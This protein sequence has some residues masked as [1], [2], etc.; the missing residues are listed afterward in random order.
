MDSQEM[1]SGLSSALIPSGQEFFGLKCKDKRLESNDY[2]RR[3]LSMATEV[4]HQEMFESNF[5]LQWNE[6]LRGLAVFGTCNLYTEWD[7]T[8]GQLNY[9][10]YPIS[11]YQILEDKHL[12]VD[13]VILTF[14][15]TARQAVQEFGEDKVSE[16]VKE[17]AKDA[18]T[19]SKPFEFIQ[20]V[21]PRKERNPRLTDSKNWPW[22]SI[23]V[24]VAGKTIVDEGGFERFP[25][26]VARWMKGSS[27][28]YG[29]GQGTE[30][31]SAVKVL[32]AIM[33][34][35]VDCG[36]RW[37]NPPREVALNHEGRVNVTPG[38]VNY[39]AE[40]GNTIKALDAGVM[41]NFPITKE[42]LELQRDLIHK[43]FYRDIFGQLSTLTGDRR[44]TTEIIER[45]R[46]GLRRLAMPVS[47]I[48]S[49]LLTP[50]IER[51]VWLLIRN[52]R[53]PYPPDEL[54]G[55][56]GIEYLGELGLALRNQQAKGFIQWV[57]V[58]A[59]MGAVFPDALDLVGVDRGVRR[60]A[61]TSGV[62]IE[63]VSTEEEVATKREARQKATAAQAALQA[64]EVAGKAYPGATK[65]P[66]EGSPAAELVGAGKE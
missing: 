9:K 44:T 25:F 12:N 1:A 36:N 32:Q 7:A 49:E 37:V 15:F 22:E 45:I 13:T 64:V 63:D 5:M 62:N 14:T 23:Y 33:R 28:K 29:R 27:E 3:Y 47:R 43:A 10:D 2:I 38:A 31:L 17:A 48:E 6:S 55:V 4:T 65:A 57:S 58:V 19:A 59:N 66:E 50:T 51:S 60:L 41:G 35:F 40:V 54:A 11:S 61:E 34:A 20:L 8:N 42:M 46:E 30:I 26:A 24:D 39:V 21:G 16:K 52:D 53:L 18:K 56:F